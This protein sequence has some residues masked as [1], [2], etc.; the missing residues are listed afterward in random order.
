MLFGF[1][2]WVLFVYSTVT[3]SRRACKYQR[4]YVDILDDESSNIMKDN[5]YYV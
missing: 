5:K 2:R 4:R 1:I 3:L